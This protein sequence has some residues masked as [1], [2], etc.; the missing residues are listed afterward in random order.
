[1][2]NIKKMPQFLENFRFLLDQWKY[3][4]QSKHNCVK[5]FDVRHNAK[6]YRVSQGIIVSLKMYFF[7]IISFLNDSKFYNEERT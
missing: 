4:T 5:T 1:M 3:S 7:S 6:R 2:Q